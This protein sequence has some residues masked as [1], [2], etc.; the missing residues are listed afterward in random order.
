MS[1]IK[2]RQ[3]VVTNATV[4]LETTMLIIQP[5]KLTEIPTSKAVINNL[6]SKGN[7]L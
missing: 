7:T 3:N 2:N 5:I 4:P 6:F 1:N